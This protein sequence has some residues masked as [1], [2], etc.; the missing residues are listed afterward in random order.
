MAAAADREQRARW[1]DAL[2]RR[3]YDFDEG[4]VHVLAD[5]DPHRFARQNVGHEH[6]SAVDARKPIAAINP[7]VD[8][9]FVY[10]K[11]FP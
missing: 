6:N 10:D 8:S 2:R 11:N 4:G 7:L 9:D 5:V 1:R 3:C